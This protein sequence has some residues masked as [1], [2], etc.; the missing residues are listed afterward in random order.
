VQWPLTLLFLAT[1]ALLLMQIPGATASDFNGCNTTVTL[2][3]SQTCAILVTK[4]SRADREWKNASRTCPQD[5]HQRPCSGAPRPQTC[6]SDTALSN[7][8]RA[9]ELHLRKSVT[10]NSP[11]DD[12]T[13]KCWGYNGYGQ[14]G[15]GD[16]LG[17]GDGSNGLLLLPL[18]PQAI[19]I[20]TV[21]GHHHLHPRLWRL[22]GGVWLVADRAALTQRW[23]RAFLR[24]IWGLGGWLSR[25]RQACITR[26][27]CW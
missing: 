24:S 1:G 6:V 17:R 27:R 15:Y 10:C 19:W 12:A 13:V 14:L 7:K 26:A 8:A 21:I 20:A 11:Q 5:L 4:T 16:K 9:R 3:A 18:S 25:S 2:G 23:G 22:R